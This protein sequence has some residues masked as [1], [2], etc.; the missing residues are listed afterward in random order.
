[1]AKLFL[2]KEHIVKNKMPRENINTCP[3]D[4]RVFGFGAGSMQGVAE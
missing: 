2:Q 3:L 1:M 4:V